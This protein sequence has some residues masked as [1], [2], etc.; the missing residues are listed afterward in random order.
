M[1]PCGPL[2]Q[3]LD[4]LRHFLMV[5]RS[6]AVDS[7]ARPVMRYY[8]RGRTVGVRWRVRIMIRVMVRV[9]VRMTLKD[10]G[11]A[12]FRGSGSGRGFRV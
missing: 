8:Y 3:L 9:R 6:F 2:E 4:S 5:A 10:K 12:R 7:G 1:G 11:T